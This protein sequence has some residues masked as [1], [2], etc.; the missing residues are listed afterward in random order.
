MGM[1]ILI[2]T[3]FSE[4]ADAALGMASEIPNVTEAIILH[5]TEGKANGKVKEWLERDQLLLSSHGMN[6]RI[7]IVEQIKEPIEATIRSVAEEERIDCIIVG[8]R[9][10]GKVGKLLLGSVSDNLLL[11]VSR[12]LLIMQYPRYVKNSHH[13]DIFDNLLIPIE[14]STIS[15]EILAFVRSL[16]IKG[17]ITLLHVTDSTD[18]AVIRKLREELKDAADQI[19]D[20]SSRY[21]I[22]LLVLHGERV[23][24]ILS[25]AETLQATMILISRFGHLD[26][27]KKAKIGSTVAGV[28][29]EAS[30]PVY[31]RYPEFTLRMEGRELMASE[32]PLAEKLWE[33]YHQ[34]KADPKTD[35][36]FGAFAEGVLVSV[37]RCRRHPDGF[38][39]DSVFTPEAYRGHGFAKYAMDALIDSCS[40]EW[41]YMHS[42]EVLV[43]WYGRYGFEKIPEDALPKTI[44]ERYAFALGNLEGSGVVPMVRKPQR[45]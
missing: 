18:Y 44:R 45:L 31:I 1:R 10:R 11:N 34:Q 4:Y 41:L 28:A 16:N 9:G 14:L 21:S 2:P 32:F 17:Q 27:L 42:T 35:R 19:N 36:V 38:E 33:T 40:E 30:V 22:S 12:D 26:Y 6:A 8:A 37:A 23:K 7:R 13:P 43:G 20:G 5:V 15:Y 39:V 29:A 3:D 25:V 24:T